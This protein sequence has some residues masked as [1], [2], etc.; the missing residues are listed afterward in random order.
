MQK[1]LKKR[2]R[3][4][5]HP[6][7]RMVRAYDNE[8]WIPPPPQGAVSAPADETRRNSPT[9]PPKGL[10]PD[11]DAHNKAVFAIQ[12]AAAIAV[13]TNALE[14]EKALRTAGAAATGTAAATCGYCHRD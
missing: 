6:S 7:Q 2:T 11:D 13:V 14:P 4:Y 12:M 9:P 10:I 3:S 1:L 8:G 5:C